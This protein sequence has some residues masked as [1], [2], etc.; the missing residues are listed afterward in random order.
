MPRHAVQPPEWID[1]APIVVEKSVDV[2]A[3]PATVWAY[4]ADH[5]GWPTWFTDL[6]RVEVVGRGEGVGG[7]RR[8]FVKRL[9]LEEEFT[10]WEPDAHF[11]FAVVTSPLPMLATLAESVRIEPTDGGCRVTYRQGVQGRRGL[12]WAMSLAWRAAP[13]Q[14]EGALARLKALA[15]APA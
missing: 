4:V 9:A 6:D 8:V 3:P 15:E 7:G 14:V 10:A 2:A 5:E 12:G 11:A 13:G 1:A